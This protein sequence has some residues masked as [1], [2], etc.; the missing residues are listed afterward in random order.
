MHV[1]KPFEQRSQKWFGNVQD[2]R[3]SCVTLN[4]GLYTVY[5]IH[6]AKYNLSYNKNYSKQNNSTCHQLH[7]F[8]VLDALSKY[9]N[10]IS[11]YFMLG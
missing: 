4:Y 6:D 7:C 8:H 5:S 2:I 3:D 11:Y 9:F 1:M 10:F